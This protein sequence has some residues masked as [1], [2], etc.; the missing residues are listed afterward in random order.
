MHL[1]NQL[2]PGR[3]T[4]NSTIDFQRSVSFLMGS[5]KR[6]LNT[7]K[8]I[9]VNTVQRVFSSGPKLKE[10]GQNA[11]GTVYTIGQYSLALVHW[12]PSQQ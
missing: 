8:N 12:I 9:L 10:R 11:E 1:I 5:H 6:N 4:K 7:F 3:M 2:N